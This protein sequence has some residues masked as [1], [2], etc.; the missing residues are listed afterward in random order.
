MLSRANIDRDAVARTR[1]GL[2]DGLDREGVVVLALSR[3]RALLAEQFEGSLPRLALLHRSELDGLSTDARLYLGRTVEDRPDVACGTPVEAR[4]LDDEQANALMP[5]QLRWSGLREAVQHLDDRDAGLFTQ[6][7]ALARWHESHRHCPRCGAVLESVHG[8]WAKQCTQDDGLVF[9]RTDP[10][11]IMR[12]VDS[13]DRLLLGSNAMWES[14]R[15]SLLAGFVEPGESLEAAVVREIAEEA[16]MTVDAP[17]YLGSQPWPFPASIMLGFEAR[18]AANTD[19]GAAT[20][21]GEEILE[22]RWFTRDELAVASASGA[23]L[24]PGPASIA[25]WIVDDW[26]GG[27]IPELHAAQ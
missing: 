15:F 5:E 17:Q 1:E 16:G 27:E 14:N 8:G 11:V 21:D 13:D 6:A 26:F 2:W 4:I 24:L 12:V 23:V 3:G 9:P 19:P 7:L 18:L 22:L 25:R 10:A 20:P